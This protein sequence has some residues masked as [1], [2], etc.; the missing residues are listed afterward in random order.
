MLE[1]D[2][3][4][5]YA[6]VIPVCDIFEVLQLVI[7]TANDGWYVGVHIDTH[8]A[9]PFDSGDIGVLIFS[10]KTEAE[11]IVKAAKKQYGERKLTKI[12]EGEDE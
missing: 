1:K 3:I 2:N 11:E 9:F 8:Q 7:R 4:V 12:K 5:F 6:R 10:S